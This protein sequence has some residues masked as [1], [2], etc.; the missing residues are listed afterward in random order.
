MCG[1]A[2]ITG[3]GPT[4]SIEAMA[5]SIRHRGPD[6]LSTRA[7]DRAALGH[8]RLSIIDLSTGDQPMSDSSGRYWISFNGEIYNYREL[9]RELLASGC[10]LRTHS[11]TEVVVTAWREWGPACL[12]RFRGMFAFAIWDDGEQTLYVYL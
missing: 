4:S 3:D 2:C 11:D 7:F 6:A 12:D 10:E 9:R 8:V 5:R 1:I